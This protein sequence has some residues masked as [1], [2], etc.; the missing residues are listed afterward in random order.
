MCGLVTVITKNKTGVNNIDVKMFTELLFA[1]TLRGSHGTGVMFDTK[2][3]GVQV[4]K[5]PIPAPRFIESNDY[6]DL[7]AFMYKESTFAVGHNR[8]ATKGSHIYQN[9]HPFKEGAVTLVHNGT[10]LTHRHFANVEVDSHAICHAI[11]NMGADAAIEQLDGAFALIWHDSRNSTLNFVRNKE[12]PLC[13]IETTYS[14]I[15]CSEEKLGLWIAS[16]NNQKVVESY[17]LEE[18]Y[19]NSFNLLDRT[20]DSRQVKL[21]PKYIAP[22]VQSSLLGTGYN[23]KDDDWD[24]KWKLEDKTKTPEKPVEGK[25]ISMNI[26]RK[27]KDKK[28][29]L[30]G[31]LVSFLPMAV[32]AHGRAYYLE[33][34]MQEGYGRDSEE[35]EVRYF[36]DNKDMLFK[37]IG[38]EYLCGVKLNEVR[39]PKTKERYYTLDR[40]STG[41]YTKDAKFLSAEEVLEIGC[42]CDSCMGH[43]NKS[44]LEL[45]KTLVIDNTV[46]NAK[47]KYRVHC[48]DCAAFFDSANKTSNNGAH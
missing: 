43:I 8:W 48:P 12:R 11:N 27:T 13:F 6:V 18:G 2:Q 10:L 5:A 9:T 34:Y 24:T 1:D 29:S 3:D 30:F 37:L 20:W 42:T 40:I 23:Y 21:R 7:M 15:I 19:L 31:E 25:V 26:H 46:P 47:Q 22:L 41:V 14:W 32:K 45:S 35:V 17:E 16:R 39:N 33:G 44:I 38:D 28:Q 4:L 36:N